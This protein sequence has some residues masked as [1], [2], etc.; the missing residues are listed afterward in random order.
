MQEI[1]ASCSFFLAVKARCHKIPF[2]NSN[3]AGRNH[4][5]IFGFAAGK[6]VEKSLNSKRIRSFPK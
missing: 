6:A 4:F 5:Q 2:K 3:I 1:T